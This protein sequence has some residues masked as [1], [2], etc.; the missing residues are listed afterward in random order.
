VKQHRARADSVERPRFEG[1]ERVLQDVVP[2]NFEVVSVE[3]LEV[4]DVDV[5]SDHPTARAHPLGEPN[6]HRAAPGIHFETPPA[7]LDPER[8][9]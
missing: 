4:A 3:P 2:A 6:R 7:R 8:R 5:G 9:R 1:V